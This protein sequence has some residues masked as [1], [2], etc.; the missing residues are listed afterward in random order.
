MFKSGFFMMIITLVSRILG[1]DRS[2]VIAY[3]FGASAWLHIPNTTAN[4]KNFFLFI[5]VEN[6]VKILYNAISIFKLILYCIII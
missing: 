5:L 1:L 4:D 2:V 6:I 3:Y